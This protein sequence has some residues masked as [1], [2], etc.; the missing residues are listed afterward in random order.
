MCF[1]LCAIAADRYRAVSDP[2]KHMREQSRGKAI[3]IMA[4]IWMCAGLGMSGKFIKPFP[5][6][7]RPQ[8]KFGA[9]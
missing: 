7:Y 6:C 4:I 1:S 8:T 9:R 5:V 3:G 2:L